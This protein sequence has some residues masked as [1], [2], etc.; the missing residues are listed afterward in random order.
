MGVPPEFMDQLVEV[1][2]ELV[3]KFNPSMINTS[4][5][6]TPPEYQG[7]VENAREIATKFRE[8]RD[9]WME[10]LVKSLFAKLDEDEKKGY[11]LDS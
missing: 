8:A 5:V 6:M 2:D 1:I 11:M 7:Q 4:G 3:Q 9:Y 10:F